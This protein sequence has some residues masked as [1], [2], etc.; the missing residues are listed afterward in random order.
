MNLGVILLIA[1]NSPQEMG[2]TN[3]VTHVEFLGYLAVS[4]VTILIIINNIKNILTKPS[5]KEAI[6]RR[7]FEQYKKEQK[8]DLDKLHDKLNQ[9]NDVLIKIRYALKTKKDLD[10]D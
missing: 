4:F 10:Q 7:E 3:G 9:V 1:Q 6:T 8:E 2:V 5:D